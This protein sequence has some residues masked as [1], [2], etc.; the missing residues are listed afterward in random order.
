MET[1]LSARTVQSGMK[2]TGRDSQ[3]LQTMRSLQKEGGQLDGRSLSRGEANNRRSLKSIG[4]I[5]TEIGGKQN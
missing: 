5:G 3:E 1:E 4:K 2:W